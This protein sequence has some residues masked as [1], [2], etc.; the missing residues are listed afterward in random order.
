MKLNYLHENLG[1]ISSCVFPAPLIKLVYLL[2]LAYTQTIAK[3]T[4][5]DNKANIGCPCHPPHYV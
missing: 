2:Y 5:E 4:P 3:A 1:D